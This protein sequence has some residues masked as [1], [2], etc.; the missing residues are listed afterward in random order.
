MNDQWYNSVSHAR[1][2]ANY[3]FAQYVWAFRYV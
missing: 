3:R 2:V 1:N